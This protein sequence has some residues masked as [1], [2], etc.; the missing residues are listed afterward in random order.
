VYVDLLTG[1]LAFSVDDV[2]YGPSFTDL[3]VD[4]PYYFAVAMQNFHQYCELMRK[5][6]VCWDLRAPVLFVKRFADR[7]CMLNTLKPWLFK[8][9]VQFL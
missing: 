6:P 8:E 5:I 7:P 3:R 2:Y 9:A 4:Q 1:T